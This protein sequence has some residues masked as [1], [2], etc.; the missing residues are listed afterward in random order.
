MIYN[1]KAI[2]HAIKNNDKQLDNCFI[3]L[4]KNVLPK[5]INYFIKKGADEEAIR[6]FF[7]EAII[8]FYNAVKEDRFEQKASISTFLI[9]VIN[10]MWINAAK[11]EK[12]NISLNND[13]YPVL[14]HISMEQEQVPDEREILVTRF[15]GMLKEECKNILTFFI[16]KKCL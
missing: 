7:Q 9:R 1:D 5:A 13:I 12:K 6:D 4:Y 15:M 10:N 11:K 8:V 16:I 14:E 3:Y 2:I